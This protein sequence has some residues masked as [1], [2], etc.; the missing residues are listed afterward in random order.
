MML[1]SMI[2]RQVN[3]RFLE[4]LSAQDFPHAK[5]TFREKLHKRAFEAA[6]P[7]SSGQKKSLS[8]EDVK[9]AFGG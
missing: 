8:Y 4:D 3:Q 7:E 9:K 5:Q 1:K 6:F 2:D